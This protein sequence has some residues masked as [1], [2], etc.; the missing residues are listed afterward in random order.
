MLKLAW[1]EVCDLIE[2]LAKWGSA[3]SCHSRMRSIAAF[4]G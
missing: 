4:G 1:F 3:A 2:V